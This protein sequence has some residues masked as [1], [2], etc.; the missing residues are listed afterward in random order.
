[1]L[2]VGGYSESDTKPKWEGNL[3]S[4]SCSWVAHL[5]VWNRTKP[6]SSAK[7]SAGYNWETTNRRHRIPRNL[8]WRWVTTLHMLPPYLTKCTT[9][10]NLENT[11]KCHA[12]APPVLF[13]SQ[14][15]EWEIQGRIHKLAIRFEVTKKNKAWNSFKKL[16]SIKI[17]EKKNSSALHGV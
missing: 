13:V 17:S 15:V 10:N 1:M 9:K 3:G 2:G 4:E 6:V 16:Q 7:A 14:M 5:K 8:P 12:G 11:Q